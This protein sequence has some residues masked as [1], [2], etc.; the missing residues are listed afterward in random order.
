MNVVYKKILLIIGATVFLSFYSSFVWSEYSSSLVERNGV[1]YKKFSDIPFTGKVQGRDKGSFING[2]KEG[3]WVWYDLD[4]A[5]IEKGIFK[6]GKRE[7]TWITFHKNNILRKINYKNGEREG[8]TIVYHHNGQLH[9]KGIFK[10]GKR[11]GT[12]VWHRKNGQIMDKGNFKNDK[13]EGV[14]ISLNKDGSVFKP[15]SGTYRNGK[16]ISQ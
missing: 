13:K 15:W 7:G 8:Y 12:W 3:P 5:E 4:G 10:N 6:N 1:Y 14:W 2:L 16:K 9:T 11:E